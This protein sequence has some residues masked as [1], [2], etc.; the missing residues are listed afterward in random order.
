MQ[1]LEI[2]NA[3]LWR[4]EGAFLPLLSLSKVRLDETIWIFRYRTSRRSCSAVIYDDVLAKKSQVEPACL[5]TWIAA[6]ARFF[7]L[8]YS[9][10]WCLSQSKRRVP[11][12]ATVLHPGFEGSEVRSCS[13]NTNKLWVTAGGSD[14]EPMSLS[15]L[16]SFATTDLF[17]PHY[18]PR[19]WLPCSI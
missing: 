10:R 1:F 17:T 18:N 11:W 4:S 16:V 14:R 9:V 2:F 3:L 13:S 15:C 12:C 8:I 6:G 7:M 5:R 19:P